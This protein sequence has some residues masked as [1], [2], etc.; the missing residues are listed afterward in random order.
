MNIDTKKNLK[1]VG[2]IYPLTVQI[3]I[4]DYCP[5]NYK[6]I[7]VNKEKKIEKLK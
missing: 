3:Q 1:I 5:A 7:I 2:N 6:I 4:E